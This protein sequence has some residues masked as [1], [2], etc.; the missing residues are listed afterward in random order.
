MV[1]DVNIRQ[2]TK[3]DSFA[4][5]ELA[6]MSKASWGYS[7]DFLEACKADLT[8]KESDI[9]TKITYVIEDRK[10]IAGFYV[11]SIVN[12][13]LEALFVHPD[14]M[15]KGIGRLLWQEAL[16]Q[17]KKHGLDSFN[18]YSDPYAENFYIKMGAD[19]IGFAE[20]KVFPERKLPLLKYELNKADS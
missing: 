11:L 20:S 16:E 15:G 17:S 7:N 2:A 1:E 4:L 18:I 5:T 10:Q 13:E 8:V 6:L 19:R 3:E 12:Q 9:L 14:Y